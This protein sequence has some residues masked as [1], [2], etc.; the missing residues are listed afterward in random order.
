MGPFHVY[1]LVGGF[2]LT[3]EWILA[4]KLRIANVQFIDD[5]KLTKK[6]N[7]SVDALVLLRR[8]NKIF[9]GGDTETKCGGETAIFPLRYLVSLPW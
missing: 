9:M 7:Q 2:T 8:W 4:Q 1:S 3:D 5:M 6:G